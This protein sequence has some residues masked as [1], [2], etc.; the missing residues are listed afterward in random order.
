MAEPHH[1]TVIC[2]GAPNKLK[3]DELREAC[4]SLQDAG[5]AYDVLSTES[6]YQDA[7]SYEK[8]MMHFMRSLHK[9]EAARGKGG[10]EFDWTNPQKPT[11]QEIPPLVR[12]HEF[13]IDNASCH[14]MDDLRMRANLLMRGV[15]L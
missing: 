1:V 14:S 10:V 5:T 13:Q 9:K 8:C 2:Q 6:G 4:K 11:W 15:V 3:E 7:E 12:F